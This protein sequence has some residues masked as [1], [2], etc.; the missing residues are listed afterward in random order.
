MDTPFRADHHL[1]CSGHLCPV[2]I[3]MTEEKVAEMKKDEVLEVVF[4]DPGAKPDLMAWCRASGHA[5]LDCRPG[6]PRSSA[7]IRKGA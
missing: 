2:P 1:D 3:I 4:T 5:F 6:K 7:F